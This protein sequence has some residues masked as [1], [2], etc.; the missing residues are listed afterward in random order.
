MTK[1]FEARVRGVVAMHVVRTTSDPGELVR[2]LDEEGVPTAA[3]KAAADKI[4][5]MYANGRPCT[6]VHLAAVVDLSPEPY[7]GRA[8]EIIAVGT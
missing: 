6:P 2:L 3:R 5:E 1:R 8:R 7:A 4:L